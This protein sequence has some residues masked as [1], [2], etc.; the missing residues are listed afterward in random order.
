MSKGSAVGRFKCNWPLI[1]TQLLFLDGSTT[2]AHKQGE[3]LHIIYAEICGIV[4][5][6]LRGPMQGTYHITEVK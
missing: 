4:H 6:G 5:Q 2:K 1:Y 3:P